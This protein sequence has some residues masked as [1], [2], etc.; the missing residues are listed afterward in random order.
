MCGRDVYGA[1]ASLRDKCCSSGDYDKCT[2]AE[3]AQANCVCP[4]KLYRRCCDGYD[5]QSGDTNEDG[6]CSPAIMGDCMCNTCP[7]AQRDTCCTNQKPFDGADTEKC[8][9]STFLACRC[10]CSDSYYKS[11]CLD[12]DKKKCVAKNYTYPEMKNLC[13]CPAVEN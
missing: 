13:G 5:R 2:R 7:L 10:N 8:P 9:D 12:D 1:I 11:C 6:V 3:R 4:A